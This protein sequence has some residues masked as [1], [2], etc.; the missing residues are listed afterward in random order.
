MTTPQRPAVVRHG[1][2]DGTWPEYDLIVD[3][4]NL[5]PVRRVRTQGRDALAGNPH[6]VQWSAGGRTKQTRVEAELHLVGRQLTVINPS[7]TE[8]QVSRAVDSI[9]ND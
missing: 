3:G 4:V 7:L 6:F 8:K 9:L 5:G 2:V 1:N